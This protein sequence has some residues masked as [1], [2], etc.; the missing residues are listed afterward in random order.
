[1]TDGGLTAIVLMGSLAG[2]TSPARCYTPLVGAAL[3]TDLHGGQR[4]RS[5]RWS[6]EVAGEPHGVGASSGFNRPDSQDHDGRVA[7]VR[8]ALIEL[9]W[10][11]DAGGVSQS[12]WKGVLVRR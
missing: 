6:R 1:M 2:A 7:I 5:T 3:P 12:V 10:F 8:V 11:F 4:V 9:A